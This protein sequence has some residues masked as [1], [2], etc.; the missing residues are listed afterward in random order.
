MSLVLLVL[1]LFEIFAA[2]DKANHR[3]MPFLKKKRRYNGFSCG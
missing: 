2:W 3:D 1:E